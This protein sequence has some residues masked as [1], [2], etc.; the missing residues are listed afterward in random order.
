MDSNTGYHWLPTRLIDALTADE[1]APLVERER[2]E[3]IRSLTAQFPVRSQTVC[4]ECRLADHDART[5]VAVCVFPGADAEILGALAKL[6]R[7]HE[8][9]AEWLRC[10][11]F[12]ERWLAF[13][14]PR[15]RRAPFL[16]I[17]FDLEATC[18]LPVPCLS[19]C[20]DPDFF[21]RRLGIGPTTRVAPEEVELLTAHCHRLLHETELPAAVRARLRRYLDADYVEAKHVSLMLSRS[22]AAVKVDVRL[23][24]DALTDYLTERLDWR[25]A[26]RGIHACVR[27]LLPEQRHVQLNLP[28][29]QERVHPL[30]VEFLAGPIEVER[31]ARCEFLSR[32]VTAGLCTESKAAVLERATLAPLS[33]SSDGTP[34]ARAWYAKVRFA[35]ETPVDAKAYIGVMPRTPRASVALDALTSLFSRESQ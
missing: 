4:Y 33:Y 30:E 18:V 22:P 9:S 6:R 7:E 28:L 20:I 12:I 35:G 31:E 32:L 24:V 27:T 17:A 23:P 21:A 19:V 2:F 16:C 8:N 14:D 15:L 34:V 25:D 11:D 5:D 26:A 29:H 3:Q 13:D 10:I 1:L